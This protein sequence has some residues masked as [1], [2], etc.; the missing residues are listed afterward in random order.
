MKTSINE[1]FRT[2][3]KKTGLN[4]TDFYM[5]YLS[6][7]DLVESKTEGAPPKES[8][9]QGFMRKLEDGSF[10]KR[11][12]EI[13]PVYANIAGCSIDELI[14]GDAPRRQNTEDKEVTIRDL[15]TI[16][17][18]LFPD[19]LNFTDIQIGGVL[20][21][22]ADCYSYKALYFP[23]YSPGYEELIKHGIPS[24]ESRQALYNPESDIVER[25]I[26]NLQQLYTAWKGGA[27]TED[28]YK[29]LVERRIESAEK[30]M[31]SAAGQQ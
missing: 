1:Q 8:S 18:K 15:C 23:E 10:F 28:D 5:K 2:I 13:L 31:E 4:Q 21:F 24:E 17:Y 12:V 27:F 19:K 30:E 9:I 3:R 7:F 14:T 6:G 26:D 16:I 29:A 20:E 11:I 22:A 25:F